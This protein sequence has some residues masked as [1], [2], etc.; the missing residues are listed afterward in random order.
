M[1]MLAALIEKGK[2]ILNEMEI[3]APHY[4]EVLIHVHYAGVNRADLFQVEGKYPLPEATFMIPGMEVAGEVAALGEGVTGLKVGDRVA[5]LTG[6]GGYA[7]YAVAHAEQTFLLSDKHAYRDMTALPEALLTYW[8]A[9]VEKAHLHEGETVLIHAG[10]SGV[11]SIGI[12]MARELGA[13]VIATAGGA[14]K[15]AYLQSIGA[16]AIDYTKE[17]VLARIDEI[18]RGRKVDVVIDVLGGDYLAKNMKCLRSGGRMVSLAFLDG[19]KTSDSLGMMLTKNLTWYGATLGA[20]SHFAKADMFQKI[21]QSLWPAV[22]A[23]RIKPR[24]DAVF[25]LEE[26]EKAHFR[27]RERLHI[28]K[29]ILEMP[30]TR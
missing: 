27:M 18:N 21:R 20:Q 23:G 10:A 13:H 5:A 22:E 9:M 7:E 12:Q 6:G 19:P 28:G 30:V 2:L 11:G 3:P 4:G 1:L 15:C 17:D 24:I 14:E 26:V 8:L 29:I 25:P 16:D